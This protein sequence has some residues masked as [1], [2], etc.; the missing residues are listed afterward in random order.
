[1]NRKM[2]KEIANPILNKIDSETMHIGAREALHKKSNPVTL[3]LLELFADQHKRFVDPRLNIV[4]A[5]IYFEN[6]VMVGPG[7]D[8]PRGSE[9]A[10][11]ALCFPGVEVG[12]VLPEYQSGN[13]KP[14][15]FMIS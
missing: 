4:L 5:G 7:W 13:K 14:R 2:Y 6:P 10:L 3:K 9:K 12:G 11:Y 8:K 15:Q 1:M